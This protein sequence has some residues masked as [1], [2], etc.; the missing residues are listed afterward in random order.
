MVTDP[1]VTGIVLKGAWF[2]VDEVRNGVTLDGG[3]ARFD[4]F[5]VTVIELFD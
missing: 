4:R 1:P 5:T 2:S 3:L